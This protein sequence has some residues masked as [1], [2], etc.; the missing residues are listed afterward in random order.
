MDSPASQVAA[1][2]SPPT[3]AWRWAVLIA[4]SVAM[5]GNYYT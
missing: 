4:I 3:A 2:K 1:V 5:F